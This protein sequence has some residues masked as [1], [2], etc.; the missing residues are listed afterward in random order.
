MVFIIVIITA[1]AARNFGPGSLLCFTRA[2]AR[3]I[4]KKLKLRTPFSV[5]CT[6]VQDRENCVVVQKQRLCRG[7]QASSCSVAWSTLDTEST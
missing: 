7:S 6:S 2:N 4:F 1:T 3:Q 5:L